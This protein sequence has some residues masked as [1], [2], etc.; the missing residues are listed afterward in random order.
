MK[1]NFQSY[2]RQPSGAFT[3]IELLTVIAIIGVLAGMLI[4]V[5]GS[6][7]KQKF[8]S[9]AKAELGELETAIDSYHA[10]YGVYPPSTSNNVLTNQLYYELS[11][12]AA[13]NIGGVPGYTNLD[14]TSE[15]TTNT[16]GA[17]FGT[18]GFVN[19]TKASANS[20]DTVVA[21]NFLVNLKSK[22]I[23]TI[24]IG[25]SWIS[26]LVTSVGGPDPD[27][28]PLGVADVNPF[29]YNSS[30]PTNNPGTYDLWV[31]LSI[32]HKTNRISNWSRSVTVLP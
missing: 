4:V 16:I 1:T 17:A 25:G 14:G 30:N 32:G 7:Q 5:L 13:N 31:D 8:T 19:C 15:I 2:R 6:L 9:A 11:G 12:T 29:R 26:N 10:T 28:K 22:Q 24:S 3:L 23:G 20:E 18:I 27:Y 21:K